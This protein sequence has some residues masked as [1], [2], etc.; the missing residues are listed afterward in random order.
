[1]VHRGPN[2]VPLR[3]NERHVPNVFVSVLLVRRDGDANGASADS[4]SQMLRAGHVELHVKTDVKRLAV[5][6]EPAAIPCQP[7]SSLTSG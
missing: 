2:V 4:A 1:M 7:T 5:S 6:I 3:V